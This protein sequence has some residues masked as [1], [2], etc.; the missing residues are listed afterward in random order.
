L[1]NSQ[2]GTTDDCGF[3]P[4]ADDVSTARGTAFKKIQARVQ[5]TE[6]AARKLGVA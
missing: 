3:S 2:L 4:F 5:G 6:L 1:K